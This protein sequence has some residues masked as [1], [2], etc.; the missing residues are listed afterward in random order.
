LTA[1]ADGISSHVTNFTLNTDWFLYMARFSLLISVAFLLLSFGYLLI[2][3]K[4]FVTSSNTVF[5]DNAGD[6]TRMIGLLVLLA[7]MFGR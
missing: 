6:V 2:L 1:A 3:E 4:Y 5:F 7:A